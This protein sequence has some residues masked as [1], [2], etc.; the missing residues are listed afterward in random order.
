[1]ILST[2]NTLCVISISQH[3]Q[4]HSMCPQ[5]TP[6]ATKNHLC[7]PKPTRVTTTASS[8][9]SY[10]L[11]SY[12]NTQFVLSRPCL[13]KAHFCGPQPTPVAS[14]HSVYPQ[15]N[16]VSTKSHNCGPQLTAISTI[17]YLVVSVY[18]YSNHNTLCALSLPQ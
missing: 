14:Q 16:H 6:G 1:M 18:P 12:H 11:C 5:T 2:C 7:G 13:S 3:P 9:S 10:Y 8:L 4:K 17:A 15:L